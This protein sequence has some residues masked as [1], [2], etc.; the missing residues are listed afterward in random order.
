MTGVWKK[1]IPSLMNDLEEFKRLVEEGVA[2]VV[3]ITRQQEFKVEPEELLRSHDKTN[4]ELLL[5]DK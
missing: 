2:D 5:K 4:E 3:E 1:L